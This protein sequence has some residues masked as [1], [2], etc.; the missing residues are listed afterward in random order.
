MERFAI[1]AEHLGKKYHIV[2]LRRRST[3]RDALQDTLTPNWVGRWASSR[4]RKPGAEPSNRSTFWALHDVSFEIAPGE[5]VGIVGHNGAGKTTLLKILSQITAPTSGRA[6]LRGRVG[7]L[8]EVGTGFHAELSGRENVYLN[9]A[10]LG[11]RRQEIDRKFDEIVS[12]A[13]VE[14]FLDTPVKFYSDGMRTRLAFA[15]AA[16]LEPEILLVDEVLAVGDAAFQRKSLRRMEEV[17][18]DGRTVL[19]VS[20]N[21]AAVKALCPKSILL[22]HGR[23]AFFGETRQ[24]VKK[25]LATT[26]SSQAE[27]FEGSPQASDKAEVLSIRTEAADGLS[28]ESLPH[29]EP[30]VVSIQVRVTPRLLRMHRAHLTLQV[31]NEALETIL[32]SSDFEPNGESLMPSSTGLYAYRVQVPS[33]L[34]APGRYFLSAAIDA[35]GAHRMWPVHYLGYACKFEIYD[36]GSLLAQFNIP[37][38][39]SI[40]I[41]LKWSRLDAAPPK[42]GGPGR[43]AKTA[44]RHSP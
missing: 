6:R 34:L 26:T 23:M 20:H 40:H 4:G 29:D 14:D 41:P 30:F 9:G 21:L 3:L 37:W 35:T 2:P 17:T 43:T 10:V 7:S 39:G 36:N 38:Q 44:P 11:M 42:S 13:G 28:T 1:R 19:F 25:Y 27:H 33:N 22:E 18:Y 5:S 15:V 24:A 31:H 12:F 32:V 8:L 16:H